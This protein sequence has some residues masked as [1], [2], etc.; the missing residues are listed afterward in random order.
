MTNPNRRSPSCGSVASRLLTLVAVVVL[1]LA[2]ASTSVAA[3]TTAPTSSSAS[4]RSIVT[5]AVAVAAEVDTNASTPSLAGV[6]NAVAASTCRNGQRVGPHEDV[7]PGQRRVRG[8]D[9]DQMAVGFCVAAE[10]E[11]G[12]A[13]FA[14][15]SA[16]EATMS[17]RAGSSSLEVTE[18]AALRM[19]QRGIS[20]DAA[21]ATLRQSSFQ[22]F[23]QGV[24]KTGFYDPASRIF[25]GTVDGRLTTVID[26]V[27]ANYI[28]NLQAA[29]P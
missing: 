22:Y 24:W 9:Y 19:T 14:V 10:A 13:R 25:I 8:P 7:L 5:R 27:T 28:S 3:A 18:H 4:T 6:G 29:T 12:G 26:N 20:I 16:G 17:L 15:N 1:A 11:A 23:H 2:G 21:E